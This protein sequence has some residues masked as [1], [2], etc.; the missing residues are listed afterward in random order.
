MP[1]TVAMTG[2]T[3]GSSVG[4]E[5]S[6]IL[7]A[8]NRAVAAINANYDPTTAFG[9]ATMLGQLARKM[10]SE[11]ANFR[12]ELATRL[13]D[14]NNLSLAELAFMLDMSRARAA[15]LVNAGRTEGSAVT[16]PGTNPEPATVTAAIITHNGEVLIER[17]KD[18]IPPWTFPAGEM[19]PGESP[20]DTVMRRVPEETGIT[21]TPSHVIGRRIHPKTG[22]V[23]IYVAASPDSLDVT[24]GDPAD[25]A[26]VRFM[27]VD[28]ARALM[29]DMYKPV[30]NFLVESTAE[31]V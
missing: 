23:M 10:E 12:A 2:Y 11:A 26:E 5:A 16:D 4:A 25:A 29:P 27:P 3:K 31:G 17:R 13:Y 28:D 9:D 20:V 18:R 30:L 22:R 6:A 8:F 24:N 7:A 19:L 14:D 15:Q 1:Y 21:V